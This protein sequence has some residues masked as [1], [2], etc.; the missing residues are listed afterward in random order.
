MVA[1]AQKIG[2][3]YNIPAQTPL[4][5]NDFSSDLILAK[6]IQAFTGGSRSQVN[7]VSKSDID[8]L[9]N[10]INQ[11]IENSIDQKVE[12]KTDQLTHIIRQSA[13]TSHSRI[14]YSREIGEAADQIT[15]SMT[16]SVTIFSL[17][18]GQKEEIIKTFLQQEADFDSSNIKTAN[19]DLSFDITQITTNTATA[20]L[21]IDGQSL[22]TIDI[23]QIIK[24]VS[25][26]SQQKA[27]QIIKDNIPRTYNYKFI[28]NFDFLSFINPL[29]F[30][31]ENITIT[32]KSE[33]P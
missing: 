17:I 19:F 21:T 28:R 9:K 26:K 6:T 8:T 29:S 25:G 33:A 5:F 30:R 15:S 12:E 13:Q 32:I 23:D 18:D 10:E 3:E 7:A 31:P 14:D 20:V 24:A 2:P 27:A 4:T 1:I 11:I 22:P 16:T